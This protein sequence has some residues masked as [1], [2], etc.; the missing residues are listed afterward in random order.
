MY[1]SS[2]RL[3]KYIKNSDKIDW[4]SMWNKFTIHSAEIDGIEIKGSD[5][6]N[7]VVA[8]IKTVEKH[9]NS[10]RLHVVTVD[11]GTNEDLTIVC[12]APNLYVGMR[13]PCALIGGSLKGI[14][15]VEKIKLRGI[16]SNGVLASEK[17]LGISDNHTGIMELDKSYQIGE[18]IKKYIPID[19][20]VVEI[21]NKSLTNRPDM[22]G[23]YGIARE[24]AAITG[25]ALLPLDIYDKISET[26]SLNIKVEDSVNCNRY[27]GI[28]IGNIS[29]KEADIEMKVFLYYCGMRS[30]SLLVDLT[31]YLM[32][33]LGTPMHAF[34]SKKVN[35]IVVKNTGDE[36]NKFVTLDNIE[37][38]IPKNTLM[39]YDDNKPIAIAGIMGGINSE[40]DEDTNSILLES[41]N[42]DATSIR[43]SAVALGLR[44]E[45][46]TRYEKS[47]D[48]N[49]TIL[50]IKRF[51]YLLKEHDE[52]ITINSRIEDV[53]PNVL[54]KKEVTLT[55]EMLRKYI[56]VSLDDET[57]TS[58]LKSLDFEVEVK[59][60]AYL[61]TAP[62]YR[63][64]KDITNEA[65]II[66]EI[67]RIYGYDN[68]EPKPLKLDLVAR[69]GENKYE[70]EN[71]IKKYIATTTN[72]HEVHSYLWYQKDL[73]NK[74]NI[75]K[76]N[77]LKITNKSDNNILRDDLTISLFEMCLENSKYI[78]EYG[79]FE[80]GSCIKGDTEERVLAILNVC[81][82]QSV[83]SHYHD[84]KQLIYNLIKTIRNKKVVFT[85]SNIDKSYLQN[86]YSLNILLDDEVIGYISLLD[87]KMARDCHK[88]IAVV[89]VE[90]YIEKLL[91]V[92]KNNIKYVEPLKYPITNVDYTIILEKDELYNNLEQVL[93]KYNHKYLLNYQLIDTYEDTVKKITIRFN[94]G[95]YN[96]TLTGN[97]ITEFQNDLIKYIRENKY[98][99]VDNK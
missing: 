38:T 2:N 92:E 29:K 72:F 25:N 88:K 20:I 12:G 86:N 37:R 19:D 21:D 42:F 32:L 73:L 48:P 99:I 97:E 94:I 45:A 65:D 28:E 80:I 54:T 93:N 34:D 27:S 90:L 66:E 84:L 43:K 60:N 16:E 13:V 59:E 5:I 22:W 68:L 74:Y 6:K 78:N 76:D 39:I 18:D 24:I 63:S 67:A 47:L 79:I 46:S 58:I 26:K 89:N 41:A 81:Q 11:A 44:T 33:E 4:L 82:E 9:P 96:K 75:N 85:P 95:S 49:L 69:D 51:L 35:N 70:L 56:D 17:E 71:E 30:V 23:H 15:K 77:N 14:P 53:Y 83:D 57:V 3:K 62:T 64:T 98:D 36:E 8:E 52:K 31:N 10:D 40:I 50:A 61:V 7:V 91:N 87:K 55:K 1:I